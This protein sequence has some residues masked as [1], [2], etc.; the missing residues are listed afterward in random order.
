MKLK[1]QH[2]KAM[3]FVVSYNGIR[4][5]KINAIRSFIMMNNI[6]ITIVNVDEKDTSHSK[7][8]Q[9]ADSERY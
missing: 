6:D 8:P 5:S 2:I 4:I 3:Y 1:K 7:L 9:K